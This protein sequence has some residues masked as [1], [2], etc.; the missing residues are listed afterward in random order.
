METHRLVA[1]DGR[2]G[3]AEMMIGNSKLM[4]ADEYP[5]IDSVGPQTRGGPTCAFDIDVVDAALVD[6]TFTRA[7]SLGATALR[8]PADQFHGSRSATLRDPFGHQWTISALI[9]QLT[10]DEY[11]ARAAIDSGHGSFQ[12]QTAT[13]A[14][15]PD[16]HDHQVKH[17]GHGDLYYFTLPVADVAAAQRFFGAVLGWQFAAPDQGHVENIAAPPGAVAASDDAGARLYFVVDDIHAAV[18]RVREMGGTAAEPVNY[19]SG[20]SADCTDD[21]GTVFSLSVPSPEYSI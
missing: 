17:H 9:E 12:L 13:P 18:Q 2:I 14:P 19:A 10:T 16:A 8:Q 20:W 11:A 21:Q 6:A 4:L 7:L 1:D 15:S 3:H 5:E